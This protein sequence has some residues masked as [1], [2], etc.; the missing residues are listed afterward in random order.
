MIVKKKDGLL[1]KLNDPEVT[2]EKKIALLPNNNPK[3]SGKG[4]IGKGTLSHNPLLDSIH[5][6]VGQQIDLVIPLIRS[7]FS[8]LYK[9]YLAL[10]S[11][12]IVFLSV[13]L[14]N[15]F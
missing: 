11:V 3:Q 9:D 8:L 2:K 4:W 6:N 15:G 1:I 14:I 12:L 10:L 5:P 7:V 13:L